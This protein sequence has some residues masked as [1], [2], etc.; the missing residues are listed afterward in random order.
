MIVVDGSALFAVLLDEAAASACATALEEADP[1]LM[2]AGSLTEFLIV[3]AR[4]DVLDLSQ[5]FITALAPTIVPVT[6]QRA[7]A[8]AEAARLWGKGVH[9]ASLNFGDCFAYALAKEHDCPLLFVGDDFALTDVKAALAP[10]S[11]K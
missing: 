5:G 1:L 4:K 11:K 9:P 8:A 2:S 3:A 6:E 7:R 10:A